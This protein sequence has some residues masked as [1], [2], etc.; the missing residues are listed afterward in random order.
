[1][2]QG[3]WCLA[4]GGAEV[5]ARKY[6]EYGRRMGL[7]ID[8][9][10]YHERAADFDI[11]HFVGLGYS[12]AGYAAL[13]RKA[14]SKVVIS[15]IYYTT[16]WKERILA[17]ALRLTHSTHL[18]SLNFF[19]KAL[20]GADAILPNSQAEQ[21]QILHIFGLHAWHDRFHVVFN[22]VD[23]LAEAPEPQEFRRACSIEGPYF[24][25]VGMIDQRKNTLGL[26]D[27]FAASRTSAK[28]V[29]IGD[30]RDSE[31]DFNARV[32]RLVSMHSE[33]IRHI[34]FV[35][36]RSLL[37][38]AYSGAIAHVLPSFIETPG[39]SNLEAQAAGCPLIVGD[40]RPVREYFGANAHY[41]PPADASALAAA[42]DAAE[43]E[44]TVQ[45]RA[46]L[47]NRFYWDTIVEDLASVYERVVG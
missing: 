18:L 47:P 41:V 34:P 15:P 6:V 27:G 2:T 9:I 37:M 1:M 33:R 17:A 35:S 43:G 5:Q 42:I 25:C 36:S 11:V 21:D 31:G 23:R 38:S 16:A 14:G 32:Q 3:P 29:L 7:D 10:D 40:C 26:L 12:T 44:A 22:G 13:A 28:L 24:L 20:Q 30:F 8:F 19:R 45:P 46:A 39:L 4:Y